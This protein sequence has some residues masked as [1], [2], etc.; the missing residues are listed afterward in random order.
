MFVFALNIDQFV[1]FSLFSFSYQKSAK[2]NEN[3][4]E[5]DRQVYFFS[6]KCGWT[7]TTTT[8]SALR[9][10][11][12]TSD[13]NS[14]FPTTK[15]AAA[16]LDDPISQWILMCFF[17]M[18]QI[19]FL[20]IQRSATRVYFHLKRECGIIRRNMKFRVKWD[21]TRALCCNVKMNANC[22]EVDRASEV[23]ICWCF[24]KVFKVWNSSNV[25]SNTERSLRSNFLVNGKV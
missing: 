20:L 17:F 23:R 21:A 6:A 25:N 16:S 4:I 19:K 3:V 5:S 14:A 12:F 13:G 2:Q 1:P 15:V 24:L 9:S 18:I 7:A 8:S 22:G 10:H 11:L